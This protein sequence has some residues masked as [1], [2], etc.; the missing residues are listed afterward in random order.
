MATGCAP[1]Y[2]NAILVLPTEDASHAIPGLPVTIA[3]DAENG[4]SKPQA[5]PDAAPLRV[6]P[7]QARGDTWPDRPGVNGEGIATKTENPNRFVAKTIIL[8]YNP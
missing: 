3:P 8:I 7:E 1:A 2:P 4:C 5:R 6:M